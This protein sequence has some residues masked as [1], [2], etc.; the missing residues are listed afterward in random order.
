MI[1]CYLRLSQL[2]IAA[3]CWLNVAAV[4]IFLQSI[5]FLTPTHQ[6]SQPT[7]PGGCCFHPAVLARHG[8]MNSNRPY[9]VAANQFVLS[10]NHNLILIAEMIELILDGFIHFPLVLGCLGT[11]TML[12]ATI[13]PF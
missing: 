8:V 2:L 7:H 6:P 3:T 1:S 11:A 12:A 10:I 9:F 5:S 4:T 13:F